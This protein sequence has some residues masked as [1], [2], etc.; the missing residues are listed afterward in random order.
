MDQDKLNEEATDLMKW[1]YKRG[2]NIYMMLNKVKKELKRVDNFPPEV[3]ISVCKEFISFK[4]RSKIR[5]DYTWFIRVMVAKSH[6]YQA[7][8]NINDHKKHK[9]AP[10]MAQNVKDILKGML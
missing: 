9:S 2:F 4:D 3:I 8:Q 1:V 6:E 5:N 10:P 7:Q